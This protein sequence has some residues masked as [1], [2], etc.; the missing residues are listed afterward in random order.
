MSVGKASNLILALPPRSVLIEH[1]GPIPDPPPAAG[2]APVY[3]ES[4][5][6]QPVQ[7][8]LSFMRT[9]HVNVEEKQWA[10][11]CLS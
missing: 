2:G 1:P 8:E 4:L 5:A 3:F 11:A 10:R 9:E 6:L 7:L